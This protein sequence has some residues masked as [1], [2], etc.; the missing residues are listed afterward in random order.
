M[1]VGGTIMKKILLTTFLCLFSYIAF[2]QSP[3]SFRKIEGYNINKSLIKGIKIGDWWYDNTN[4]YLSSFSRWVSVYKINEQTDS[5]VFIDSMKRNINGIETIF[6]HQQG[7]S[8][9]RTLM[10]KPYS[11]EIL[12]HYIPT[13]STGEYYP[14]VYSLNVDSSYG[15]YIEGTDAG[16]NSSKASRLSVFPPPQWEDDYTPDDAYMLYFIP[17]NKLVR[18]YFN[19]GKIDTLDIPR[20]TINTFPLYKYGYQKDTNMLTDGGTFLILPNVFRGNNIISMP[21]SSIWVQYNSC[22]I[23][24]LDQKTNQWSE[25][26]VSNDS[27]QPNKRIL[28]MKLLPNE[29]P[30]HAKLAIFVDSAEYDFGGWNFPKFNE[31]HIISSNGQTIKQIKWSSDMYLFQ[32]LHGWIAEAF[33]WSNSEIIFSLTTIDPYVFHLWGYEPEQ[34][35]DIAFKYFDDWQTLRNYYLLYNVYTNESRLFHIPMSMMTNYNKGEGTLDFNFL[36]NRPMDAVT[37]IVRH[38]GKHYFFISD[39]RFQLNDAEAQKEKTTRYIIEYDPS[40][41]EFAGINEDITANNNVI[42]YPNT[43]SDRASILINNLYNQQTRI[44]LV[45]ILGNEVM[46]ITDEMFPSGISAKELSLKNLSSG[47]YYIKLETNTATKVKTIIKQ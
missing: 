17:T 28:Q 19:S 44:S 33:E 38:D 22:T 39:D 45:D 8:Y 21:D 7:I 4:R 16:S 36:K 23:M 12:I 18:H 20:P 13:I 11:N 37:D 32:L 24:K 31:V 9:A 26:M 46:L 47:L 1:Q 10:K 6:S 40:K 5:V 3:E 35:D 34:R 30:A 27:T 25:F 29:D 14:G 15:E 2:S 43:T 41:D 42:V